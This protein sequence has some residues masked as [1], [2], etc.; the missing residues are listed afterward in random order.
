MASIRN[1]DCPSRRVPWGSPWRL[2][3]MLCVVMVTF[4]DQVSAAGLTA[5]PGA[6]GQGAAS[7][8]GRGGDVYHVTNLE[9]YK[10]H[11]D[12]KI[13][14]SLRH[15]IRSAEAPRTIVFDV[16][17]PILLKAPLQILKSDLTIAGQTAPGDGV[18]L[19]GYPLEISRGK[20]V[21]IRYLRVR[22]GDF[23]A[24]VGDSKKLHPYKGNGDL[25]SSSANA[26]NVGG[27][28][29]RVILDH[30]SASW[31]IDETLSVTKCRDVTVQN[32]IIALSLNDSFHPKGRHG[33]GTLIRGE[34][35][36]EDQAAGVGG[37]TFYQNLWAHHRARNPSIGGQ[38]RLDPGQSEADRR[39]TDVNLVN[40]VIYD[41][42]DQPTHR[43]GK[44]EI[45]VNLIGNYYINGPAKDA[46]RVF[47]EDDPAQTLVYQRENWIDHD[48]DSE[49][50]GTQI[51]TEK[52]I[53]R[54]F[55]KLGPEDQLLSSN[56]DSPFPFLKDLG[57]NLYPAEAAYENALDS[58]GCS[59]NRDTADRALLETVISRS[60][61]LIDSQEEL[62]DKSG[63]L[64]GI[65]DIVPEERA[66]DFDTDGDG[67]PNTFELENKLNPN[68]PA[69]GNGKKLSDVGYTN[70][71]VYLARVA[72]SR[73]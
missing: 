8:G 63:N 57:K 67:M 20:D 68:D 31:G 33:Y 59:L 70:L 46:D 52:Q 29:E 2:G 71:E 54:T 37:F 25:D 58:V 34:L 55:R 18:T 12:K 47:N 30:I 41:W 13:P 24:R 40:N 69:D 53:A 39:R 1:R 64:P 7:T 3:V 28:C 48:Q 11:E 44:G 6:V 15:A 60:G 38:Q 10:P 19:W 61:R 21:V 27:D 72:T 62:R 14:G 51:A 65:D 26:I 50:N 73:N 66:K 23:H 5:F 17:G 35:T 32:C 45:R 9:D 16:G 36:P 4:I 22:L 56:D 43:S 42:L 49:H